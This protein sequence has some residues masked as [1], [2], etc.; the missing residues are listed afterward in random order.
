MP[1]HSKLLAAMLAA[2]LMLGLLG[3]VA[4]VDRARSQ[5]PDDWTIP[6]E[7][8]LLPDFAGDMLAY[9]DA[10]RYEID[11]AL[12]VSPTEAV[13]EGHQRVIFTNRT[14]DSALEV[15]VFRL[16]PNLDSF[17]AA[18]TVSAIRVEGEPV[19]P[20]LDATRSVL[21][22]PLAVPLRPGDTLAIEMDFAVTI[23]EGVAPLYGQFS[24][25]QGVLALPNLYPVLSVYEPGAGWW[26]VT[27]HPQGD[28]T[29]SETGFYTVRITAP[30]TLILATSG[31]EIDLAAND[32]GTLTHHY[33]APLMRDFA[34]MACTDYVTL[35]GE[36]DGVTVTLYYTAEDEAATAS[37]QAGL[38]MTLDSVRIFNAVF[39]RYPFRELDVV[40]TPTSAGGIEYPGLFVVAGD[41]WNKNDPF[42][43]FVIAHEAAHQWWYSLVGNDQTLDPWMDEG[44]A[45][46]SVAQ[47]IRDQEGTQAYAASLNSFRLQYER[48]A[49]L[50]STQP[51]RVDAIGQPVTAYTGSA[52]FYVVY[53]R[54]PLFFAALEDVY[55]HDMVI[56]M[57]QD[58]FAAYR[59]EVAEPADMLAS[60]EA[61]LGDDLD[62]IF[63]E[64]VGAFPVG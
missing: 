3:S 25:T 21:T 64:W 38:Q 61:T 59:Y 40:E 46:F 5:M 41:V 16:L 56:Q 43:E 52:Y 48:F 49:G 60:F 18:M 19:E 27:D 22:V 15:L 24:Y 47:Y 62:A 10:P 35:T 57:L 26:Q 58:Y 11:M 44:L 54:A 53:Q 13:V 17:G 6:F 50:Q 29:Y 9:A 12:E 14:A 2:L 36:Q 28:V 30:D 51:G 55:G 34:V 7:A 4:G 1:A 20:T 63:T 23:T 31:T 39:G 37:A 8:A 32:D 45:Q 33:V 42:F